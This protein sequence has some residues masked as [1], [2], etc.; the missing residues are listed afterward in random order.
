MNKLTAIALDDEPNGLEIIEQYAAKV[1]FLELKAV[2]VSP[3]RAMSYLQENEV[4]VLFLD[5]E[6]PDINGVEVAKMLDRHQVSVIFVTAFATY[7]LEGFEVQAVDYLLK[8]VSFNRFLKAC[9]KVKEQADMPTNNAPDF[10]F[11][12]DGYQLKKIGLKDI[13]YIK[14]DANLLNIYTLKERVLTRMTMTR[15]IESLPGNQFFRVHKSYIVNLSLVEKIDQ[16]FV[17]FEGVEIPISS[18]YRTD[19]QEAVRRFLKD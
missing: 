2:F 19:F 9:L 11:V 18:A 12:K 13:Q 7:A 4:H 10:I 5:I 6:M 14:S 17:Y 1:D 16:Q 3:S 8:P 15:I